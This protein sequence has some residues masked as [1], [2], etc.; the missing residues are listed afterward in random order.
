V[1]SAIWSSFNSVLSRSSSI[2]WCT[3]A[4]LVV[5]TRVLVFSIDITVMPTTVFPAPQG[6]TTTP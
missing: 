5:S 3:A 6:S 2:H 4:T 1:Y